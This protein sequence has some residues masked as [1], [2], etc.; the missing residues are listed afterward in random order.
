M[1]TERFV[2]MSIS[3]LRKVEKGLVE[4]GSYIPINEEFTNS[5]HYQL[6]VEALCLVR[7]AVNED[8]GIYVILLDGNRRFTL[9]DEHQA[10]KYV[11]TRQGVW[12][13][14]YYHSG[15]ATKIARWHWRRKQWLR[16]PVEI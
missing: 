8:K 10:F 7:N 2:N 14:V 4:S 1:T 12:T 9:H 13:M 5:P 16:T 6:W 15:N 11:P 3:D